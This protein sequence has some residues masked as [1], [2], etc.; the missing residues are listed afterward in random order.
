MAFGLAGLGRLGVAGWLVGWL[1][2][3]SCRSFRSFR[4]GGR[5]SRTARSC[6]KMFVPP[7]AAKGLAILLEK[8]D[9]VPGWL[10]I[11]TVI[12][13]RLYSVL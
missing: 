13:P 3:R 9:S 1:V 12:L 8:L 2:G 5:T 7:Y 11:P 6:H 10:F 4:A